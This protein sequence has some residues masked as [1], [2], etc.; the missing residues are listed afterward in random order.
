MAATMA[1]SQRH[2]TIEHPGQVITTTRA[3][4]GLR[5]VAML[6]VVAYQL[7][8]PGLPGG[9]IGVE[10]LFVTFGFLLGREL[11][12]PRDGGLTRL[13]VRRI[14]TSAAVLLP[15]VVAGLAYAYAD[16]G[17]LDR[18]VVAAA[19]AV[20]AQCYNLVLDRAT[21]DHAVFGNLW[22]VSILAQFTVLAVVAARWFSVVGRRYT[23]VLLL[24]LVGE[25][26]VVRVVWLGM[27]GHADSV[28]LSSWFRFDGLLLGLAAAAIAGVLR[29]A[30]ADWF[31]PFATAGLGVLVGAVV[32][33]PGFGEWDGPSATVVMPVVTVAAFLVVVALG[34]GTAPVA[35]AR[36]LELAPL[37]WIGA[38]WASILVWSRLV[39]LVLGGGADGWAVWGGWGR[40]GIL[41][42]ASVAVG[43]VAHELVVSPVAERLADRPSPAASLTRQ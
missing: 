42:G 35:L 5:G 39:A 33:L 28:Y 9:W 40:L 21:V 8:A 29:R 2:A 37:R 11:L 13:L 4:D 16:A 7:G 25:I 34:S 24:M 10:I 31:G 15:V 14:V 30:E 1:A 32:L 38:A 18:P 22:I 27:G 17:R 3:L 26:S 41:L 36:L 12:D 43:L 20:L 6:T 19:V 23:T